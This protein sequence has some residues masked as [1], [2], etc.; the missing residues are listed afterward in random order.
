[1]SLPEYTGK[2]S[3][4]YKA[5][6]LP[7]GINFLLSSWRVCPLDVYSSLESLLQNC[8]PVLVSSLAQT[9]CLYH[10][11]CDHAEDGISAATILHWVLSSFPGETAAVIGSF[12]MSV[13]SVKKPVLGW[14]GSV[15]Q[16]LV[17]LK[18]EIPLQ[19]KVF[20]RSLMVLCQICLVFGVID[21][22]LNPD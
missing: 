3:S 16:I 14:L 19:L 9:Y 5:I 20:S 10:S 11:G 13:C 21:Y 6:R 7:E 12:S 4:L 15:L 17:V 22:S 8:R 1:M 2:T 18:S